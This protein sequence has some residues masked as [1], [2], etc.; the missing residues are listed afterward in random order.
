[1]GLV[2]Y[3]PGNLIAFAVSKSVAQAYGPRSEQPSHAK[4]GST[5]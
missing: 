1:M 4:V 5:V 3:E 2:E